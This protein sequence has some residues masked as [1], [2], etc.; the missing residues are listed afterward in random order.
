MVIWGPLCFGQPM[1]GNP[2]EVLLSKKMVSSFDTNHIRD[3]VSFLLNGLDAKSL[4]GCLL[5]AKNPAA[6][7]M[8]KRD[9]FSQA[10]VRDYVALTH[11]SFGHD[12]RSEFRNY[13]RGLISAPIDKSTYSRTKRCQV[14]SR[15]AP[16]VTQYECLAE[17]ESVDGSRYTLLHLR[18]LTGRTHQIRVHCETWLARFFC[19][20]FPCEKSLIFCFC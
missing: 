13:Y 14:H 20:F 7:E 3:A 17:Y 16:S 2:N 12:A 1:Q 8:A 10:F 18:L 11:G 6:F 19:E 15:G 5:M 4:A 9:C